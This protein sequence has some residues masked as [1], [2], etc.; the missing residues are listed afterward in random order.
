MLGVLQ[1]E[2]F[3]ELNA[4]TINANLRAGEGASAST[5][6]A[7]EVFKT[8]EDRQ[9]MLALILHCADISNAVKPLSI[10]EK[11]VLYLS[12]CNANS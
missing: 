10:A 7:P 3:Y 12:F 6:G 8:P 5:E 11:W 2:V 1:L 4:A 9:F